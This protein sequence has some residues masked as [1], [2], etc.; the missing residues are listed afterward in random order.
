[1]KKLLI[2]PLLVLLTSCVSY[3]YPQTALQDGVYYAEDDPSYVVYSNSY[4]GAAYYPWSS[5]DYFYLGYYP[6]PGYRIGYGY[7]GGFSFGISYGYS[8]W[9]YPYGYYGYYSP[10]YAFYNQYPYFPARRPYYGYYSHYN[11][12]HHNSNRGHRGGGHDNRY[13]GNA[14]YDAR[15][16]GAENE[17]RYENPVERSHKGS[18]FNGYNASRVN[19][20]VSTA[21]SGHSSDR[22]MVIRSRE[23]TKIGKSRLEPNKPASRQIVS[24]APSNYQPAQS[25]YRTRQSGGEVRYSAGA[26]Q[27][28]SRTGPVESGASSQGIRI[29][30]PQSGAVAASDNGGRSRQSAP[31]RTSRQVSASASSANSRRSRSYSA[32][33]ASSS[34]GRQK[35]SQ[36][37]SSRREHRN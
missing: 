17:D 26:K 35:S 28:R 23:T 11:R 14:N 19:R 16:R 2:L 29:S 10:R 24:V 15:N 31:A 34:S 21:P 25:N 9:Y 13:A 7:G 6:Y 20:Y 3:Y 1:M 5:L 8:P 33:P 22:G 30:A 18:Q 27:G 4:A 36:S 32:P 12:G 37:H